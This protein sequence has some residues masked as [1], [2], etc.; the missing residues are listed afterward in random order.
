M[1]TKQTLTLVKIIQGP[2]FN[3]TDTIQ[4]Y[5]NPESLH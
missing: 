5:Y 1:L 2:H 3:I 4:I